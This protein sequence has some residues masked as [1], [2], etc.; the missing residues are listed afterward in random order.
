MDHDFWLDAWANG[1]IGFHEQRVN[2]DLMA[3]GPALLGHAPRKVLVPLCGKTLD[4]D[5]LARQGHEVTGVELCPAAA[6]AFHEE[7]GRDA[8]R[9]PVGPYTR[10]RSE[11]LDFL[12]GDVMHLETLDRRYDLIWDR[13]ASVALPPAMRRPYSDLLRRVGSGGTLL[14]V[15]FTYDPSVMSG[16]PFSIPSDDV[17]DLHPEAQLLHEVDVIDQ[18]PVFR[19]RGHDHWI[20]RVWRVDLP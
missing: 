15:T 4:L 5:W 19:E 9:E 2:P 10:H 1:R 12:V 8:H 20:K 3:H 16:P 14:L 13:A 11:N 17:L 7:Q 18:V 6:E